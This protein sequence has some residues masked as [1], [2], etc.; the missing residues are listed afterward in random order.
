M[1]NG[2]F[3]VAEWPVPLSVSQKEEKT[4][5]EGKVEN[6]VFTCECYKENEG[7]AVFR[8]K[9]GS[10]EAPAGAMYQADPGFWGSGRVRFRG[11]IHRTAAFRERVWS[12]S[13][14]GGSSLGITI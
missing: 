5:K 1:K 3:F 11:E 9:G 14:P 4:E 2:S 13:A 6:C 7:N 10:F 8:S 12:A